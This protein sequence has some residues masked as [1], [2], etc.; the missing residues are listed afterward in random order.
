ML[1][2]RAPAYARWFVVSPPTSVTSRQS[3]VRSSAQH[4]MGE[5]VVGEVVSNAE[6]S[7]A[8]AAGGAPR[9]RQE[10][11]EAAMYVW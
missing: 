6:A 10:A 3:V 5:V 8:R 7:R 4:G 1:K 11:R 9:Q 2:L